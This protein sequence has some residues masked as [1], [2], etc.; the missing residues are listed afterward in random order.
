[1]FWKNW[2]TNTSEIEFH[3]VM[4]TH[5]I[6]SKP[7]PIYFLKSN[8]PFMQ[9]VSQPP[10]QHIFYWKTAFVVSFLLLDVGGKVEKN[11][12]FVTLAPRPQS[13]RPFRPPYLSC[14]HF[15]PSVPRHP[16][17]HPRAIPPHETS[18]QFGHHSHSY[19]VGGV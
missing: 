12:N 7:N 17:R 18:S 6:C 3:T 1:M 11:T 5:S 9:Y 4:Y 13:A 16:P 2:G 8:T 15:P 10:Q 14:P 19:F